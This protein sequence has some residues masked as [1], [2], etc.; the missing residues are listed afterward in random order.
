MKKDFPFDDNCF[1]CPFCKKE[2][3]DKQP[4]CYNLQCN[5]EKVKNANSLDR[6]ENFI[7]KDRQLMNPMIQ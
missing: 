5:E 7:E 4:M 6:N 3:E 2:K 1:N